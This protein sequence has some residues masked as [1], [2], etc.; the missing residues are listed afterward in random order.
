[1]V[2]TGL[3]PVWCSISS[4]GFS[5]PTPDPAPGQFNTVPT[6][7]FRG[8]LNAAGLGGIIDSCRCGRRFTSCTVTRRRGMSQRLRI[9]A[10]P[11]GLP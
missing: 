4:S 2:E 6:D 9:V 11:A 1:V 8:R 3:V 5:A 10:H 7:H